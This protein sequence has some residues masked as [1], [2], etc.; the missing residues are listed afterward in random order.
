LD[1]RKV[2]SAYVGKVGSGLPETAVIIA[3][4]YVALYTKRPPG[5]DELPGEKEIR[6]W[7]SFIE[8]QCPSASRQSDGPSDSGSTDSNAERLFHA[9]EQ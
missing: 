2:F 8:I 1:R 3:D 5:G 7:R 9:E 6:D 4:R